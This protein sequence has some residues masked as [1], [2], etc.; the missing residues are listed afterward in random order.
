MSPPKM[1]EFTG[2]L[3]SAGHVRQCLTTDLHMCPGV[4]FHLHTDAGQDVH[5][6][7][8][9]DD[10]PGAQ[11]FASS[12]HKGARITVLMPIKLCQV[13]GIATTI[14]THTPLPT[15]PAAPSFHEPPEH[16]E[17]TQPLVNP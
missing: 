4:N 5:V 16:E 13:H 3:L 8:L 11:V 9:F 6:I 17:A 14:T 7:Q 12:L 2:T 15:Q 1:L 10:Y